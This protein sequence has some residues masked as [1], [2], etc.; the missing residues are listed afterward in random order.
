VRGKPHSPGKK[1]DLSK[2]KCFT[3]HKSG[4]YASQC[5]EKKKGQGKSQQVATSTETQL[6][7]FAAK[8]EKEF[9]LVSCLSTNTVTRSA[10]YLDNGASRHMTE[11]R[12]LFNSLTEKDS[13]IHVEL[14][15][16]AKYAVKGEGTIL[17][18]LESGGSFEAQ[19][20]A[21]CTRTEEEFALS[22][23]YGGQGF[24]H[25]VQE[26]ESTHTSRGS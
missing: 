6:D 17:F 25:H 18:Q 23:S 1:K 20:C 8:F 12:E 26:R 11:A 16:D 19:G 2:I 4:H 13:G 15:D 7:E 10:W 3:C 22:L 21:I 5:P 24:C 9:T 14:G